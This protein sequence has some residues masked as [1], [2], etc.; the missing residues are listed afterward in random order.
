MN[1]AAEYP[2]AGHPVRA[3]VDAH[4]TWLRDT[5][6]THLIEAGHPAPDRAAHTLVLLRDGA[7][8]GA[9]LDDATTVKTHLRQAVDT[10]IGC[11]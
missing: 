10:V 7:M 3:A 8:S 4:R 6:R 5:I 11:A 2:E 9:Y 1:A